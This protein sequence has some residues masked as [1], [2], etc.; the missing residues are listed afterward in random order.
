MRYVFSL[1]CAL[2]FFLP[3]QIYGQQIKHLG[4]YDG[5]KSGAV[6]AFAKDSLGYMWIGTAQGLN[7]YSG[8]NFKNYN[9]YTAHGIVDISSKKGTLFV[10]GSKGELLQYQYQKDSF[11]SIL[12]LKY[13]NFLCFEQINDN[14]IIIGLKSGLLIYDL[15]SKKLSKVLFPN[16]LFNRQIHVKQNKVYVAST[17][18]INVYDFLEKNNQLIKHKTLLKN[19]ETLDFDFD[20][21]NR[22]WAGTYRK[23]LFV[24]DNEKVNKVTLFGRRTKTN[25]IRS[26]GFDKDDKALIALE[27]VGLLTMNEN[28][29]LVNEIKYNPNNLN[30]LSQKSIYEIFVDDDNVYWLGLREVGIDLIL[31]KDNAFKNI[32]YVPYILA[33]AKRGRY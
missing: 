12:N 25:T 32:S 10:L 16:T 18:G 5:I 1:V 13:R 23:G 30:S 29:K 20:K 3:S 27:G 31:P 19:I 2:V 15:K 8:Y 11:K 9:K 4:A 17:K 28:F 22:I 33:W 21:Q 7:R 6:R 24:I 14:T 26:I